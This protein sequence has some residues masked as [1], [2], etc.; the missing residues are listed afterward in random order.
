MEIL[1]WIVLIAW[2]ANR[3]VIDGLYALQGKPIPR[4]E[5]AKAK[6]LAAS[7]PAPVPARYGTRQWWDDLYSDALQANTRW[8]RNRQARP[9]VI[10][11]PIDD[12]VDVV[13]EPAARPARKPEP[14]ADVADRS[15]Q[16]AG[17]QLATEDEDERPDNVIP[18]FPTAKEVVMS[19][20]SDVN[21]LAAA[22]A[23]ATAAA[24]AHESFATA[25]SEGYTGALAQFEVGD[26]CIGLAREA[27]EA[28]RV[29]AA[30]WAAHLEALNKQ[31]TVKEAYQSNPDAGSKAFL[32]NG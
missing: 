28:S 23:F 2:M 7:K 26:E 12:M 22:M 14:A 18:L 13:R 21:G 11:A 10:D 16:T 31:Q 30:K 3:V 6:A 19:N 4:Y 20:G 5:L 24:E 25:G 29:A 15:E 1:F 17:D 27:Q 8:R 32:L 9:K